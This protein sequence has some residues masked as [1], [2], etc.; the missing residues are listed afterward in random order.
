MIDLCRVFGVGVE[1][2]RACEVVLGVVDV[3][4]DRFLQI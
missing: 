4:L 1:G 2:G 3:C